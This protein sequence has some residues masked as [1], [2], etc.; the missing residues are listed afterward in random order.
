MWTAIAILRL[1]LMLPAL[2][3]GVAISLLVP[4][5]PPGLYHRITSGWY[6][7]ML[8]LMG[9]RGRYDGSVHDGPCLVVSNHV[10]W[11]DIL[12][13]GARWPFT[14]LAMH[15]VNG[16]PVVGWLARRVGTLFIRRGNGAPDA[17]RQVADVLRDGRSVIVFPEGRTT[18][19]TTVARFHPR[20][21]QAAVD[22]VVPV[23]PLG[24]VYRDS[25]SAAGSTTRTT[26]S[27]GVGFVRSLWCTIAGPP[28][29]VH[30]VAFG[31][32]GPLD[33]RQALSN[34][35]NAL[36]RAH[37]GFTARSQGPGKI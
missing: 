33:D 30:V 15:E 6:R 2:L 20:I 29:N 27:D 28:V 26:F 17:I 36:I 8:W 4:W 19:G 23:Q 31:A 22:A 13:I 35:A 3:V 5:M 16:W 18:D 34:Q 10:S 21:F 14:F 11:A 24:L 12:V 9:I 7:T 37:N 32:V 1:I 25:G